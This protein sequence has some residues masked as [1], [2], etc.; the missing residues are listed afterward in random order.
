VKRIRMTVVAVAVGI[1]ALATTSAVAGGSP[2]RAPSV[3]PPFMFAATIAAEQ[4]TVPLVVAPTPTPA[5]SPM[6]PQ[7]TSVQ[8]PIPSAPA[9]VAPSAAVSAGGSSVEVSPPPPASPAIQT[10]PQPV[11]PSTT[12]VAGGCYVSWTS[13]TTTTAG[14]HTVTTMHGLGETCTTAEE[15]AQQYPTAIVTPTHATTTSG[16]ATVGSTGSGG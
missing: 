13:T 4:P 6:A 9:A 14:T 16:V 15:V 1:G 5:P 12:V 3:T 11:N 2:E 7:T 10:G 8:T